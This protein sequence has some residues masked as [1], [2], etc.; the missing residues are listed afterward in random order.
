MSR[1][2]VL[3]CFFPSVSLCRWL[4]AI[5]CWRSSDLIGAHSLVMD[6]LVSYNALV[7]RCLNQ[8]DS[9]FAH[10]LRRESNRPYAII[11]S[12]VRVEVL[13]NSPSS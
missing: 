1:Q 10:V 9:N 2:V 5:W 13:S 11:A 3:V 12:A 8:L 6:C 7:L 4:F